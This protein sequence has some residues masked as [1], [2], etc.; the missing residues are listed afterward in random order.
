MSGFT[1]V[2]RWINRNKKNLL[3]GY[4]I[5]TVLVLS[6]MGFAQNTAKNTAEISVKTSAV[7]GMCKDRIEKGLAFEKGIK[8][9]SLD[10]KSKIATIS[11]KTNKTNPEKIRKAIS[12]LGYDADDVPADEKAY[13]KLPACCKKDAPPH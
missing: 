10:L 3:Y 7:C 12:L 5:K 13:E 4:I 6:V 9:V 1:F 2:L 11:Y 8:D